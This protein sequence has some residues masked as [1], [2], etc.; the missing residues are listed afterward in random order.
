MSIAIIDQLW[1]SKLSCVFKKLQYL[2]R[3]RR[4]AF[5]GANCVLKEREKKG[6]PGNVLVPA[7][8]SMC[9]VYIYL[10]RFFFSGETCQ[11]TAQQREHVVCVIKRRLLSCSE[12]ERNFTQLVWQDQC[13]YSFLIMN[14]ATYISSA[15]RL[16]CQLKHYLVRTLHRKWLPQYFAMQCCT[17]Q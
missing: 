15:N 3:H 8:T 1:Q 14:I 16:Y 11:Y 6:H 7:L 12:L 5:W 17:T 10:P 2:C 4:D 9:I 13:D